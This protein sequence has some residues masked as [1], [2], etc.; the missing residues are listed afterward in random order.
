MTI[1]GESATFETLGPAGLFTPSGSEF[2]FQLDETT[3]TFTSTATVTSP[4]PLPATFSGT[5]DSGGT[6]SGSG[7]INETVAL[8][9]EKHTTGHVVRGT[10]T[11]PFDYNPSSE[12]FLG[13][14]FWVAVDTDDDGGNG[15]TAAYQGVASGS[16]NACYITLNVPAGVYHV[17]GVLSTSGDDLS[18]G[19]KSGDYTGSANGVVSVSNSSTFVDF[20]ATPDYSAMVELGPA[21]F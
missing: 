21:G 3:G 18:G 1:D 15:Q 11:F 7:T 9:G 14:K 5:I 10:M 2:D 17:Y 16:N 4:A 8:S 20:Y 19:A 6:V 13:T 12:M